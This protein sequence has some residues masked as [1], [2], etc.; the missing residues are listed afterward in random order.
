MMNT[1][2]NDQSVIELIGGIKGIELMVKLFYSCLQNDER[3]NHFFRWVDMENQH[4]LMKNFFIHLLDNTENYSGRS[5]K[6]A[7]QHLVT[8]GLNDAHFD[9]VIEHFKYALN[10]LGVNP[11][12]ISQITQKLENTRDDILR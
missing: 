8:R 1:N 3:V 5:L 7:H 6:D 9:A 12:L 10:E 2:R 4:D 11:S